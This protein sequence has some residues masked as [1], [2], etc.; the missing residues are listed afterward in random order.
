MIVRAATA[1]DLAGYLT[2]AQEFHRASP[3]HDV[4]DFDVEGYS[5]FYLRALTDDNIGIWLAEANG[6]LI[7][8][9]GAVAYPMYFSPSN[10]VVQELW[11]WLT[12]A[13]RGSGA[14]TAMFNAIKNW[15]HLKDAKALLMIALEDDRAKK[16]DSLYSR[17]GFK[18]VERLF[19][20][21]VA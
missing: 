12:P 15:A 7:G 10:L 13:A 8:I 19:M 1:D 3:M 2:L 20:K 18:P 4:I 21:E 14:G 11:W 17:A 16:M 9:V 6:A 5:A